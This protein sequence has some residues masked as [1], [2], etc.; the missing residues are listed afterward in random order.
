MVDLPAL[1]KKVEAAP[2]DKKL[3][4]EIAAELKRRGDLLYV[5]VEWLLEQNRWPKVDSYSRW[6][7]CSGAADGPC[8]QQTNVLP[9]PLFMELRRHDINPWNRDTMTQRFSDDAEGQIRHLAAVFSR[10]WQLLPSKPII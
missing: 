1:W 5:T 4:Q 8:K 10:L 3:K 7:W 6:R 2:N 9:S